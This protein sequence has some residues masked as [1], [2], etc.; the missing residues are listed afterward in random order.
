MIE[1]N[2]G[3]IMPSFVDFLETLP[4]CQGCNGLIFDRFI[5]KLGHNNER[6]TCWHAS[7]YSF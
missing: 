3:V 2:N 4:R 1:I 6:H 7:T 5:L